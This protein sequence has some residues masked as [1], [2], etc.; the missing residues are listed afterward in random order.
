MGVL[1]PPLVIIY[2][3]SSL[4]KHYTSDSTNM[5]K[6]IS[7]SILL[8]LCLAACSKKDD[9]NEPLSYLSITPNMCIL[10]VGKLTTLTINT[11][12]NVVWQSSDPSVATVQDGIITAVAEGHAE[13][14]ANVGNAV[15]KAD[16]YVILQGGT[17][18]GEYQ[19]VWSEE[20]DGNSLNTNMWNIETGGG[21]WGNNEKQTYTASENNL[22]VR[23]GNLEIEARKDGEN[24][25]TSARIN[26]KGKFE[27]AYAKVEARI[28]M[29]G[30]GGTWPAF[31]MLG[32]GSWPTC[33][34]IDI[35]EHVGNNPKYASHA[36]H[37]REKNGS[38][39]N[40]WHNSQ[41]VENLV[42][43]YHVFGMEWLKTYYLG[44]DAIKFYVDGV[45]SGTTYAAQNATFESWP[46]TADRP[47]FIILNLALGGNMGGTI[48]NDIF[49]NPVIMYVDWV[50]VYQKKM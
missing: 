24:Y 42:G 12:E 21:G 46:F 41:L 10:E 39:G 1:Q 27:V 37:T 22:R 28:K 17:Y 43:E 18:Q 49:N 15:G 11:S 2:H 40:N 32:K 9:K 20:F 47:E 13:I 45:Y 7:V 44:V 23:N 34:E 26:T 50:R 48:N 31:W 8:A 35:V 4:Y 36:V 16:V 33:G 19:L 14:T 6:I 30:G 5:K 3:K 29:P 38:K 25:Y